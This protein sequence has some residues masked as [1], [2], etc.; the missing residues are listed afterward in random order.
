MGTVRSDLEDERRLRGDDILVARTTNRPE[1]VHEE[2]SVKVIRI[3]FNQERIKGTEKAS[4][5]HT[6]FHR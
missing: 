1:K 3:T 5:I 6:L 2:S 4:P